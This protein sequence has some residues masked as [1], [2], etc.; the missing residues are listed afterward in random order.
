LVQ[1][2]DLLAEIDPRGWQAQLE[3]AEG[4]KSRDEAV[5]R[6]AQ[7]T[8]V[9][10]RQLLEAKQITAQELDDQ[11]GLVEQAQAAVK[12]DQALV[13]NAELQLN[14][15][16][17][18]APITGRIGLR[19]V[20]AG[21]I[22]RPADVPGIAVITALQPITVVFTIPQDEI[23]RAR[24][25]L[26]RQATDNVEVF[27]RD[28]K[29]RLASGRLAAV[30][31]QVDPTTG[32]LRLKAEFPNADEALYP[33]QFV[34]VRLHVE[35]EPNALVVPLA[36]VQRGPDGPYVYAVRSDETVEPRPV[37]LGSTAG[38]ETVVL[39]GVAVGE[40]VVIRGLDQL[41][42]GTKVAI[43]GSAM[44]SD[45]TARTEAKSET[46]VAAPANAGG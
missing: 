16:R 33:N 44:S 30:D 43:K 3:Q 18:V 37:V 46:R 32:T 31:N 28:F 39:S 5:L 12:T 1:Q 20:D 35:T 26:E 11:L 14:Y 27:G 45:A 38:L 4:Q 7:K 22:V 25:C 23:P 17:I 24:K 34:N 19:G 41:R 40:S 42:A 10:Y 29:D 36:A 15:C 13:S 8:L 9:R 2:G 6:A 21:N